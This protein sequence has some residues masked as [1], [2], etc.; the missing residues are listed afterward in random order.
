MCPL[1]SVDPADD[2]KRIKSS[3]VLRLAEFAR[4]SSS[5]AVMFGIDCI[6]ADT[7][8]LFLY[9]V[10]VYQS[11][12]IGTSRPRDMLGPGAHLLYSYLRV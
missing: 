1:R 10:T 7:R 11:D 5:M 3:S 9:A 12:S 4:L 6:G 2:S 8:E